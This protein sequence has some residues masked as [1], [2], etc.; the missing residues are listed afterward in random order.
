[1]QERTRDESK[2]RN[3]KQ[4]ERERRMMAGDWRLE[5]RNPPEADDQ[6]LR[7]ETKGQKLETREA[8]QRKRIV[9]NQQINIIRRTQKLNFSRTDRN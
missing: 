6:T 8:P 9:R 4:K 3:Q 5:T 1:M 2:A 7:P